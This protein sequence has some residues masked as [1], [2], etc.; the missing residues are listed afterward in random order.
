MAIRHSSSFKT[1][2]VDNDDIPPFPALPPL[3]S[4]TEE[5]TSEELVDVRSFMHGR[6][7]IERRDS[8]NDVILTERMTYQQRLALWSSSSA[9][10]SSSSSS[11]T[12]LIKEIETLGLGTK[13]RRHRVYHTKPRQHNAS[14]QVDQTKSHNTGS[15]GEDNGD[16]ILLLFN[17]LN[18]HSMARS[19]HQSSQSIHQSIDQSINQ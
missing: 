15:A 7:N 4:S 8:V 12:Q 3:S 19:I 10:S 9:S 5:D 17:F 18:N 14:A 2:I 11:I 6:R 1:G 16:T 13:R